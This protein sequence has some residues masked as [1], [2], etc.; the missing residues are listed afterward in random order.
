MADLSG[1]F[2]FNVFPGFALSLNGGYRWAKM[3]GFKSVDKVS[4]NIPGYG[5]YTIPTNDPFNDGSG[6]PVAVD[7]TGFNIGIGINIRI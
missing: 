3:S 5:T 2:E 7:F 6:K 1:A 4:A